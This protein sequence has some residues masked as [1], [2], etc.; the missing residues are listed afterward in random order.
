VEIEVDQVNIHPNARGGTMKKLFLIVLAVGT[1]A[2]I[3]A[4]S[5]L[6]L[7][8]SRNE[9]ADLYASINEP[10]PDRPRYTIR[11]F[12]FQLSQDSLIQVYPKHFFDLLQMPQVDAQDSVFMDMEPWMLF[13]IHF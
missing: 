6:R 12:E 7:D 10:S 8:M 1:L 5:H 9:Q 2:S 4:C 11:A 3:N 13:N